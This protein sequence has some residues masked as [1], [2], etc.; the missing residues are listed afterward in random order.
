MSGSIYMAASGAYY[1]EQKLDILSNN[2]ANIN[3][4]GFKEEKPYFRVTE[5]PPEVAESLL[6][7]NISAED[8]TA[9]L[10][11]VLESQTVF[12]QGGLRATGSTLDLALDGKGFFCIQ[13]PEGVRYTRNGSFTRNDEGELTTHD[14]LPVL[15]DSGN[16]QIDG[17]GRISVDETGNVSVGGVAVGQLRIVAFDQPNQ[18]Q[19]LADGL[20]APPEL[21]AQE[22][23]P[24]N[25]K[26]HQG[27]LE[28]S[29]V[30]AVRTMTEII[31][32]L[33]SYESYQKVI[34]QIDET[35]AKAIN[36]VGQVV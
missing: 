6:E 20:F 36:D 17:G 21:G 11:Q 1:C 9:P 5:P 8:P 18:L 25:V 35:E 2:L 27:Y 32:V 34:Q 19:R 14:G 31:D 30:E 4:T 26:V 16:I 10:W 3:S 28:Q 22:S 33:R 12:T 23:E 13:T 24:D 29:N 7:N 15:G